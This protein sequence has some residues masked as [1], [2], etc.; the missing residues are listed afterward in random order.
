MALVGETINVNVLKGGRVI[1]D[2]N[3]LPVSNEKLDI[4]LSAL[5]DAFIAALGE[6][7]NVELTGSILAKDPLTGDYKELSCVQDPG[8]GNWYLQTVDAAPFAYDEINDKI[9]VDTGLNLSKNV[10]T[11]ILFNNRETRS[12]TTQT[13][14]V[15]SIVK[16]KSFDIMVSNLLDKPITVHFRS[17]PS[18]H[19]MRWVLN[20]GSVVSSATAEGKITIPAD[21]K[22]VPLSA[23][24]PANVADRTQWKKFL[25]NQGLLGETGVTILFESSEAPTTG[26][27]SMILYG[28]PN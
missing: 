15:P 16:Y 6:T 26:G 11:I 12:T 13:V 2:A 22:G 5:R 9:K 3:P 24:S 1:S 21:A 20:D 14:I 17:A 4:A 23:F 19:D 10:E 28:I 18:S 8:T 25:Y 27:C 7:L